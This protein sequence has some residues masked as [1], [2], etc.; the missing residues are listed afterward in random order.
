MT[1]LQVLQLLWDLF[2]HVDTRNVGSESYEFTVADNDSLIK[3]IKD[4]ILEIKLEQLVSEN[5]NAN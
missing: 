4:R 1:E 5:K 2:T 3:L